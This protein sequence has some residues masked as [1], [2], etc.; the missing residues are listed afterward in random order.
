[1]SLGRWSARVAAV[2]VLLFSP[3]AVASSSDEPDRISGPVGEIARDGPTIVVR[4]IGPSRVQQVETEV[5]ARTADLVATTRVV[6]A[7]RRPQGGP[8]AWPGASSTCR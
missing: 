8:T 4:E 6:R 7:E 5:I 3:A 1:M 2:S